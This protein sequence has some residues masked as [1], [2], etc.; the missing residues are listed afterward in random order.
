MFQFFFNVKGR[1]KGRGGGEE[2]EKSRKGGESWHFLNCRFLVQFL[3]VKQAPSVRA[4]T[5]AF[6]ST[7]L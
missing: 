4:V 6:N 1:M 5:C 2:K 7:P 3:D